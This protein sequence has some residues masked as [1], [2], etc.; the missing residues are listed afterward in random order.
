M[1]SITC[2]N[3][4]AV[5]KTP[6]EIPVG[7]KV[8]CPKCQQPFVVQAV[9]PSIEEEPKNPF[10]MDDGGEE[11]TPKKKKKADDADDGGSDEET[12]GKGKGKKSSK[13][14]I[15]IIVAVV[16]LLFCC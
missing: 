8:K 5:L 3:C 7:K 13:N 14:L 15:L 10:A 12:S 11:E 9:E 16:V 2:T 1:P 6:T 4:N